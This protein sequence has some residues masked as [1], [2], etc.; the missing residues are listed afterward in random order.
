MKKTVFSVVAVLLMIAGVL[1]FRNLQGPKGPSAEKLL[2]PK[3]MVYSGTRSAMKIGTGLTFSDFSK[4]LQ[5][6][7]LTPDE[8]KRIDQWIKGLR[9]VHFGLSEVTLVPFSLDSVL[10]LEGRF[11]APLTDVLPQ[12]TAGYFKEEQPYRDVAIRTLSAPFN[13]AFPMKLYISDP[14]K[15][16]IFI[17][18]NRS[19]MTETINRLFDGGPSLSDNADFRTMVSLPEIRSKD[20][21]SYIDLQNYLNLLFGLV[22]TVPV[23]AAQQGVRIV[24]EEL[25]LDEWGP[26]V[27][28]QSFTENKAV[29]FSRIPND[30]P[31]YQQFEYSRPAEPSGIPA[32]STQAVVM[33]IKDAALVRQQL[34]DLIEHIAVRAVPLTGAKLPD[35]PVALLEKMLGFSLSEI[36]PLLSGEFTFWQN[37]D[38]QSPDITCAIGITDAGAVRQ[39]IQSRL[40]SPVSL[41]P[42]EKDGVLTLP[43]S[44]RFAW[45]IQPD[46]LL[47]SSDPEALAAALRSDT[48]QLSGSDVYRNLRKQLPEKASFL[49]YVNYKGF[50]TLRS[51]PNIPSQLMPVFSILQNLSL[52]QTAVAENGM[53]RSDSVFKLDVSNDEIRDCI[54]GILELIEKPELLTAE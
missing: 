50:L 22:T 46:R 45:S 52:M 31:L 11:T 8:S 28:G 33:Q 49:Q 27:S 40:L 35:H 38:F 9:G 14:V 23:P 13:D 21:I 19:L 25:R 15:D 43:G 5:K 41:Q 1:I 39:F 10:I 32:E 48:P 7:G 26:V 42:V 16:R 2:P 36:D 12:K 29:S 51:D 24:K 37:A 4:E 6:Y 53:M 44:E 34:T 18:L 54:R 20:V 17:T 30:L 47:I 3:I